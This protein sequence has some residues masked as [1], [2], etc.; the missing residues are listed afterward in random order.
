MLAV[1]LCSSGTTG[2]SKGVR[3]S[4]AH[5]L[6]YLRLF[7]QPIP[8][9]SLS[10]SPIFWNTG[11]VSTIQVALRKEDT[12]IIT[13]SPFSVDLLVHLIRLYKINFIKFAPYQLTLLLQSPNMDPRDF[14]G[15]HKFCV[16]G[17]IV[18]EHLRKAYKVAFPKLPMVIGYGM[19]ES[20]ISISVT[21]PGD[22]LCGLTVGRISPNIYVKIVDKQGHAL[23]IGYTGEILA[24]PEFKFMVSFTCLIAER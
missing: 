8:Y 15:V 12:R 22:K 21:K 14:E 4:H 23:D 10:F 6:S 5:V 24:K 18:S 9:R 2:A 3:L 19:S 1:I 16:L 17:S 20:C 7:D 11:L 13:T